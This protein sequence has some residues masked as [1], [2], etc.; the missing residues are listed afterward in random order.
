MHPFFTGYKRALVMI[1]VLKSPESALSVASIHAPPL[2]SP[3]NLLSHRVRYR[4]LR[5]PSPPT[6]SLLISSSLESHSHRS[7]GMCQLISLE[8][9]HSSGL[10]SSY[11]ATNASSI[12]CTE[13]P[14]PVLQLSSTLRGYKGASPYNRLTTT[15]LP[16]VARKWY[17]WN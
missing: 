16:Q 6:G 2:P 13:K 14:P 1:Y 10:R 5:I 11:V 12:H 8:H 17:L 9:G 7:G 4:P 15:I 3:Q